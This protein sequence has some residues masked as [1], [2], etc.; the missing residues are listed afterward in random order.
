MRIEHGEHETAL[1]KTRADQ[2]RLIEECKIVAEKMAGSKGEASANIV[3][4]A[5][6]HAVVL[7]PAQN[8]LRVV[9]QKYVDFQEMAQL[10]L[11]DHGLGGISPEQA[12]AI[13]MW[14]CR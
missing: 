4:V 2:A 6:A 1:Q 14:S 5:I 7:A 8:P 12:L 13:S 10:M 9:K 3:Q 11:I